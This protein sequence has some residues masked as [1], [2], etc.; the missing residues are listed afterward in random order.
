MN[1]SLYSNAFNFSSF[2]SG[3]VDPR[4]G[5]YLYS[6]SLGEMQ[7]GVLNGPVLPVTLQFNPLNSAFDG[8]LGLG[9]AMLSSRYD[10]V[11][12][13]LSLATGEHFSVTEL[14]SRL[15]L[16]DQKLEQVKALKPSPNSIHLV[17]QNGQREELT[18]IGA[19]KFAVPTRVVAAN[20]VAINLKYILRNGMPMLSEVSDGLH[21]LLSIVRNPGQVRITQYPGSSR[22]A[23][24]IFRL[25]NARVASIQLPDGGFWKL[26]Y[27]QMQGLSWLTRVDSPLGAFETMGYRTQ[28]HRLPDGA[29]VRSIPVVT[30]HSVNPGQGQPAMTRT[31]RYSDANFFGF[32]AQGVKWSEQGDILYLAR[33]DYQYTS[34]ESLMLN[35]KVHQ[36]TERRFNR[37]HLLASEQ[38]K[39]GDTVTTQLTEYH[40][41]PGKSFAEQPAQLRL[42][43]TSTLRY[44]NARTGQQRAEVTQTEYDDQGN[45]LKVTHPS[46]VMVVSEYYPSTGADGCPADPLGF[47][48]FIKQATTVPADGVGGTLNRFRYGLHPAVD[49]SLPAMVVP[50]QEQLYET[51]NGQPVLK[52]TMELVYLLAPGNAARHGRTKSHSV[53]RNGQKT[54]SEFDYSIKGGELEVR[55]TLLG[56]DGSRQVSSERYCA[57]SGLQTTIESDDEATVEYEYDAIGRLVRETMARGT[58]FEAVSRHAYTLAANAGV[59]AHLLSTDAHGV[60]QRVSFDGQ[61]RKIRIEAEDVDYGAARPMR[62][63][64]AGKYN[65]LGQ[66]VEETVT[67][68]L[69]GKALSLITRCEYDEWGQV[70]VTAHPDGRREHHQND[71]IRQQVTAWVQGA[72][73]AVTQLNLFDKPLSVEQFDRQGQSQG[74][75]LYTYD[76][77]GRNISQTDPEGHVTRYQYD[78]FDRLSVTILADGSKLETSFAAH[79]NEPLPIE[80][81]VAGRSLGK[82]SFDGLGRLSEQVLAG[83]KSR[84]EYDAGASQPVSQTLPAGQRITYQR[85][86]SLGNQ[87]I[88]RNAAGISAQY[89]YHP[90][91]A[92][93]ISCTEQGPAAGDSRTVNAEYS[94]AGQLKREGWTFGKVQ[95]EASYLSSMGGRPL[96]C[97]D[98][99]GAQQT[100]TYDASGRPASLQHEAFKADFAYNELGQLASITAQDALTKQAL[101]TRMRYDDLGCE[102]ER[103]LTFSGGSTQVLRSSYTRKH[104]LARRTLLEGKRTL[105]DERFSYD[106]RGRLEKYQCGGEQLAR[107]PYDKPIR[108]QRY[109]YDALNNI[110]QLDIEFPG[111]KNTTRYQMSEAD[112]TQLVSIEHSHPSYPAPVRLSYDANGNLAIDEQGRHLDY[113]ALGRLSSVAEQVAGV[114]RGYR[115]DAQDQLV[116]LTQPAGAPTIRRFYH[117]EQLLNEERGNEVVTAFRQGD[118]V[119]AQHEQG[120]KSVTTLLG[121]DLQASVLSETREG[122][123]QQFAYSPYGH[124]S[125]QG[126]LASLLGFNGQLLDPGTGWYLLGNGYRVYNPVLMRFHSPD[127]LSPFEGGGINPYAYC[128]GDPI[129]RCDPSGHIS[130]QTILGVVLGVVG[131]VASIATFG[132]ATPFAVAGLAFGLASGVTGVAQT[133]V[134]EFAPDSSASQILGWVSLGLGVA[135]LGAGWRS[136]VNQL[137]KSKGTYVSRSPGKGG[138]GARSPAKGGGGARSP[139]KNGAAAGQRSAA[140][141][142]PGPSRQKVVWTIDESKEKIAPGIAKGSEKKLEEFKGL[143]RDGNSPKEAATLLSTQRGSNFEPL[144]GGKFSI[145]LSQSQ[146]AYFYQ[147]EQ[148]RT[149]IFADVGLHL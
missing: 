126:G 31:F 84:F 69:Q 27:Q 144:S 96:Q 30:T 103:M 56:F 33:N 130:W 113:D 87:M 129:N 64:Y 90:T 62:E 97:K 94:S 23:L 119:L 28:G 76:G 120:A 146:R 149:I 35:G 125:T 52:A 78:V 58:P 99:R 118:V 39:V 71:P 37:F 53:T 14:P 102:I 25:A 148:T 42:P 121:T 136:G 51:S 88:R 135:S 72:G 108:R 123:Q 75:T 141:P 4:T 7:S 122:Q 6:L 18:F 80:L 22:E 142:E 19:S 34:T 147:N 105:R 110:V 81:K 67:D 41:L 114:V 2:L 128:L 79:S 115:Y 3:G 36:T 1:G 83:R 20:G 85:E 24:F 26:V 134:Q 48:R 40:Q 10:R 65:A 11:A 138:G 133:I 70:T 57:L 49:N 66:L 106:A 107:D 117:E 77:L 145:R 55:T 112:P 143:I 74:K 54:R 13:V 17:S 86:R 63:V 137:T 73:R 47:V 124:Q 91:Q 12:K 44:E 92:L 15:L 132:A 109:R 89:H 101:T 93:L 82:Q 8:G 116:E 59:A 131:I 45:P 61:G 95:R 127:S 68:W 111:G 38:V 104:K 5:L 46:G 140:T 21:T 9:W 98:T 139:G 60:R 29:P 16:T 43:K 50:V 100:T 32:G